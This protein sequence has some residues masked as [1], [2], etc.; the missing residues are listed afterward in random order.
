MITP[1]AKFIPVNITALL[2]NVIARRTDWLMEGIY[3][4]YETGITILQCE[5]D[6]ITIM[7]GTN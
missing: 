4:L 1:T 2:H 6:I 7:E 3:Q 5:T